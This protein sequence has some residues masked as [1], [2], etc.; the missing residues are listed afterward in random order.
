MGDLPAEP[1]RADAGDGD[2]RG[3]GL[4]VPRLRGGQGAADQRRHPP[5]AGAAPGERP[6]ADRAAQR[7]PL[8]AP[9]HA[10]PLLRGRD[11]HGRQLLPGR[12][13]RRAHPHAVERGQERRLLAGQPAAALPAGDRRSHLPL[14][15]GQ[16]RDAAGEPPLAPLVDAAVDRPAAAPSGV[17]PRH[18]RVPPA[19]EPPGAGLPAPP[20]GRDAAGG[21]QPLALRPGRGAGPLGFRGADAG[22]VVRPFGVPEDRGLGIRHHAQPPRLPVVRPRAGPGGDRPP[23]AVG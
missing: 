17:Q 7:A 20:W 19:R 1:R 23:P 11:R 12:P 18:H 4:H 10:R 14:R 9:G 21:G 15:G 3:A 13:Q 5:P 8:L 6:A 16:R 2:R 22:R